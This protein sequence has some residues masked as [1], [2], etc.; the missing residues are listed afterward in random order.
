MQEDVGLIGIHHGGRL[1]ELNPRDSELGWE[2]DPWG[3][4]VPADQRSP[5]RQPRTRR[6][7]GAPYHTR[8]LPRPHLW[9]RLRC[10]WKIWGNNSRYEALVEATCDSPGTP[11]RAP[12]ATDGLHPFCRDSFCGQVRWGGV[13]AWTGCCGRAGRVLLVGSRAQ[14]ALFWPAG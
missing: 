7:A 10:R 2:V 5:A 6:R 4:C 12:T 14:A 13:A 1:Y 9:L 8:G 3:R 11:L